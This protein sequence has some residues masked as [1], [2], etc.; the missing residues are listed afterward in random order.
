MI[1]ENLSVFQNVLFWIAVLSIVVLVA[2]LICHY[3]GVLNAQK[4]IC[5]D[6]DNPNENF[7]EP[8]KFVFNAL[9]IKGSIILLT[10][11]SSLGFLLCL[12]LPIWL[13]LSIAGLAA[14]G[15][16]IAVAFADRDPLATGGEVAIVSE[17]IPGENAGMGKVILLG[18]GVELA[19]CTM[20][21]PLKKGKKVIIAENLGSHV[22]VK[23]YKRR[24]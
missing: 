19:A 11:T 24:K 23:R 2:Y 12:F 4:G 5:D 9:T 1:F 18:D 3:C 8:A 13:A 6:I 21:K 16:V 14:N 22:V 7:D 10:I 17:N 20:N 15:L